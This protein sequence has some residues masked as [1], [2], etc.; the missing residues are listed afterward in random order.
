LAEEVK[1]PEFRPRQDIKI[2]IDK[3]PEEEKK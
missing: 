2:E 1:V 3:K